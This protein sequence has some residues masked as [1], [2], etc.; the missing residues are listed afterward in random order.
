MKDM[1][2]GRYVQQWCQI[3]IAEEYQVDCPLACG[4]KIA[5][6]IR[7]SFVFAYFPSEGPAE[8]ETD[9]MAC[10]SSPLAQ[11]SLDHNPKPQTTPKTPSE[12]TFH[13]TCQPVHIHRRD[14]HNLAQ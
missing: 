11:A 13:G 1:T 9:Q 12:T 10:Q 2:D 5:I 6:G 3:P 7:R 14:L 8:D 4:V